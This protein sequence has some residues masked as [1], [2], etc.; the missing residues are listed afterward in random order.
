MQADC[1]IWPQ[2]TM[3]E[4]GSKSSLPSTALRMGLK[5]RSDPRPWKDRK[6]FSTPRSPRTSRRTSLLE[7]RAPELCEGQRALFHAD[8]SKAL[9][10]LT[11]IHLLAPFPSLVGRTQL[12][13]ARACHLGSI[14]EA[15]ISSMHVV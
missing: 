1:V 13:E 10:S 4:A 15:R 6:P 14:P 11:F 2:I 9:Y 8:Q 12:P 3:V 7:Q 5:E